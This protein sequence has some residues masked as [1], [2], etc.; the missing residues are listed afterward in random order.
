MDLKRLSSECGI[1]IESALERFMGN[2]EIYISFLNELMYEDKAFDEMNIAASC[3]SYDELFRAAHTLKG[4]AANMGLQQLS[5]CCDR[6]V[7]ALRE[8]NYSAIP[9]AMDDCREIYAK[10]KHVVDEENR[11]A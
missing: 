3:Y 10:I 5:G 4:S 11:N 7:T 1:D 9:D 2:E 8:K 6:I